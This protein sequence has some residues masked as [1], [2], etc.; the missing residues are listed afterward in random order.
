MSVEKD[1]RNHLR[2]SSITFLLSVRIR[3]KPAHRVAA[4]VPKLCCDSELHPTGVENHSISNSPALSFALSADEK[5]IRSS[6]IELLPCED[7]ICAIGQQL[8]PPRP[9]REG[10]PVARVAGGG[11]GSC[12]TAAE[13][14]SGSERKAVT[15]NSRSPPSCAREPTTRQHG[16][17]H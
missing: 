16:W 6:L 7:G 4:C 1:P 15:A 12:S 13:R 11:A 10:L 9:T 8:E 2:A 14:S 5:S 17:R 3:C